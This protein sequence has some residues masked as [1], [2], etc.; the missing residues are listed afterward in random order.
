MSES[1]SE[2][3]VVVVVVEWPIDRVMDVPDV[4]DVRLPAEVCEWSEVTE[5]SDS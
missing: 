3:E 4:P 2:L 1:Y 5:E